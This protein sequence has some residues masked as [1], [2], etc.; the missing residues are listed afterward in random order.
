MAAE[1]RATPSPNATNLL[2]K[3]WRKP[4]KKISRRSAVL[5]SLTSA[6]YFSLLTDFKTMKRQRKKTAN[7]S[8]SRNNFMDVY[9]VSMFIVHGAKMEK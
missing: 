6:D 4:F 7:K 8:E 9:E 5:R 1:H 3:T 2:A